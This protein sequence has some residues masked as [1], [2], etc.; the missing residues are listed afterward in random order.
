M[1]ITKDNIIGCKVVGVAWLTEKEAEQQGFDMGNN[2]V[3][4][5]LL[6]NGQFITAMQDPE[7]NGPGFLILGDGKGGTWNIVPPEARKR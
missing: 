3:Q 1:D 2:P 5:I 7:G 4:K 6:S